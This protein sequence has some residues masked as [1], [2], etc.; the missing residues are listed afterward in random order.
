[1]KRADKHWETYGKEDPYYWVTTQEK[2][3]GDISESEKLD[4]FF[5]EA[6]QYREKL[7]QIIRNRLDKNFNPKRVLDY[8]CGVGRIL[9][10]MAKHCEEAVGTDISQPMLDKAELHAE[11]LGYKHVKLALSDDSLSRIEGKFDFIHSIYV[12]QHI[13]I[14]RGMIILERLLRRLNPG[15]VAMIQMTYS[16][17]MSKHRQFLDWMKMNF[18]LFL[19]LNNLIHL[20]KPDTPIMEMHNY[21]MNRVEEL[22]HKMDIA[23]KYTRYT[24]DGPF[25][26]VMLF[27]QVSSN[28]EQYVTLPEIP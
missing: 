16:N 23:H 27:I 14:Q 2:F 19:E 28:E 11:E 18:P 12:F 13:P 8:G 3:K 6:D 4:T 9:I 5:N 21:P 15:G 17:D 26:G 24:K 1:M 20:R 7:F 22:L 10:P 25:R